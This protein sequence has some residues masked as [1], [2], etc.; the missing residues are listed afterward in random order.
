MNKFFILLL[1]DLHQLSINTKT[2]VIYVQL[3]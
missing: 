3:K 2:N 1:Q